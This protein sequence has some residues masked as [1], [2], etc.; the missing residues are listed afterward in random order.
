MRNATVRRPLVGL[1][2]VCVVLIV[3]AAV[4]SLSATRKVVTTS[5]NV[6]NNSSREIRAIYL[7]PVNSDDWSGNQ[8]S[9]GTTITA[10]HSSNLSDLACSDQQVKVIAEDEDGCFLSTVVTCGSGS[11]WTVTNDTARDCGEN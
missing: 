5:V 4:T 9:S 10:G 1:V 6:V 3:F 8:L 11:T 2:G 7:S